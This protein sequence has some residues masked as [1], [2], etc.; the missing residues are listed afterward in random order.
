M[1]NSIITDQIDRD[2]D[3]AVFLA[4]KWGFH[5]LEIHSLWGKTAENLADDEVDRMARTINKYHLKVSC[6]STT[7]FLMCPLYHD[8]SSIE[9]F[10]ESFITYDDTY[11]HHL[12]KLEWCIDM[13]KRIGA[14]CLRI[15][16]FRIEKE[17]V[18]NQNVRD[19]ISDIAEKFTKPVQ[20]AETNNLLLVVENCPFSYLPRGMMTFHL[21]SILKNPYLKLLWDVG[22]SYRSMEFD[23]VKEYSDAPLAEEYQIIKSHIFNVH[24]KDFKHEN[25]R[26]QLTVLREGDIPY[27]EIFNQM[28]ADQYSNFVA[29]EPELD[30]DGVI[31]SVESL[32]ELES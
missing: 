16:P 8:L 19:I 3:K 13:G 24:I 9:K 1:K 29:L 5:Y 27:T 28:K 21:S 20:I 2:F 7:L 23:W 30:R 17:G 32:K 25:D 11:E 10:S 6:L 4:N 18:A 12:D 26:Y 22:N 15:F 31:Q 14:E